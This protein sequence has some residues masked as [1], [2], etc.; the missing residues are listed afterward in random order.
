MAQATH[1]SQDFDTVV[2]VVY[3][4]A[5]QQLAGGDRLLRRRGYTSLVNPKLQPVKI[6]GRPCL[7]IAV[8]RSALALDNDAKDRLVVK[9]SFGEQLGN[10][11]LSS[12]ESRLDSSARAGVLTVMTASRGSSIIRA[13]TS[14]DTFLLVQWVHARLVD[15]KKNTF[16]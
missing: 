1:V 16:C 6:D 7:G 5:Q 4:S 9:T 12:L 13:L 15:N 3:A 8:R 14:A 10:G 11:G 2:G